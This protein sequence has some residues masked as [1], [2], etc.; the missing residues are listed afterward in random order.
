[1][2]VYDYKY[3][4]DGNIV[5]VYLLNSLQTNYY[6]SKM[7]AGHGES[8]TYYNKSGVEKS[9]RIG[10]SPWSNLYFTYRSG[11]FEDFGP[12]IEGTIRLENFK[13]RDGFNFPGTASSKYQDYYVILRLVTTDSS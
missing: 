6:M 13:F 5:D 9:L 8:V 10:L 7:K 2:L 12:R 3:D 1:M 11:M 4:D